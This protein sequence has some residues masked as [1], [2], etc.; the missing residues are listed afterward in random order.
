MPEIGLKAKNVAKA[1]EMLEYCRFSYKMYAQ[2]LQYPLD[3]FFESHTENGMFGDSA[4]E[5][6]FALIHKQLG[7]EEQ[8]VKF[9]PIEYK[10][11]A[12]PN[13][14]KGVIYRQ[15]EKKGHVLCQPRA[16]DRSICAA[17]GFDLEGRGVD[18]GHVLGNAT[19]QVRCGYFQGKTGMTKTHQDAGWTSW[20]G[21]V[22]Y[23]PA[24]R[25]CVIV[26]RG[27]RSGA[28]TRAALGAQFHSKG[29]PDWVTDM[30]HLKG[31]EVPAFGGH[32]FT[33]GFYYAFES[34]K[35]SIEAAYK[36]ATNNQT[37]SKVYV[38]GHSLGGA[39]A[40]ECYISLKIGAL[41]N[42]LGLY[43]TEDVTPVSCFAIS[44]PPIIHGQKAHEYLALR[45]DASSIV[46]YFCP[47]DNVH[48]SVLVDPDASKHGVAS[49][50]KAFTHPRT[51]PM[52]L[53]VE[54]AVDNPIDFPAAH[55]PVEVWKGLTNNNVGPDAGYWATFDLDVAA[56]TAT[57]PA[58]GN[59]AN[60]FIA[61]LRESI[62]VTKA[63]T[64][65]NQW[66]KVIKN[67]NKKDIVLDDVQT[68]NHAVR[69]IAEIQN[70]SPN[71]NRG[72]ALRSRLQSERRN[73]I[74]NFRNLGGN[75]TGA[76][77][78]TILQY[79]TAEQLLHI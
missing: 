35:K 51:D 21:A 52:H 71:S 45:V 41:A 8:S 64:R 65:A 50:V 31:H 3:P 7:T 5:R 74:R 55:E 2:T 72:P 24:D 53:G 43:D 68:F 19:G 61:A 25:V 10:L 23:N 77:Y 37:P 57:A 13:P 69:L 15:D 27:S 75:A 76:T 33:A 32:T 16:L 29:N 4:R 67:D 22:L 6:L 70:L 48:E 42:K 30:N 14:H 63:N 46:H 1:L 49:F 26:F 11:A 56:D 39:L 66:F 54:I 18:Q 9:D 34:A 12:T 73:L 40:Q 17:K 47:K 44:A 62:D 28:A 20:L 36:W 78:F 59:L 60:D 58:L 38:T 79:L